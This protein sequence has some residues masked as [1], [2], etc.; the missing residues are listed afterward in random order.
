VALPPNKQLQ[1][2]ALPRTFLR[3]N[4][5][6]KAAVA[7]KPGQVEWI[8]LD[9]PA[10]GPGEVLLR[11]L[12]CGICTTDVKFVRAGY[13]GGPRYALG[14]ELVGEVVAAGEGARWQVGDRVAA[15]PYLPCGSCYYCMHNQPTLCPHLFEN[16]LDPGGLAERVRIPR[17]LA[18]RGLFPLPERGPELAEGGLPL[19]IAALAEPTGCCVQGVEDCGVTAGDAVLVVG[20]GPMGLLCAAV[21]RAYGAGLVIVAGLTPHRLAVAQEHYADAVIHV[22]EEHLHERVAHLTEG[23]GADVVLVA[24]SGAEAVE[25]GLS[26]LRRGGTFNIFA[27]VPEGTTIPLDLRQVHYGQ[28]RIT[29]SFGVGP[30]HVAQA[31]RLLA[32]GQV[33]FAP[34]V[35]ATF[36]FEETPEAIAYAMN[37]VGLKTVVVFE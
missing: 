19:A 34:L 35:T 13:T 36:P 18:E 16:S 21:A 37:Q 20:D 7:G 14:H 15:A 32:S 9:K 30:Y 28:I 24:V 8:E 5:L 27:G 26:A 2:A 29:G 25:A 11:P 12:A 1:P 22:G 3:E 23:R 10:I 31:L 17:P 33:D 6:M 4:T